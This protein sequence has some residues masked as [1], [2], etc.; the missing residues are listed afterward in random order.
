MKSKEKVNL[1]VVKDIDIQ[2]F[3]RQGSFKTKAHYSDKIFMKKGL[4]NTKNSQSLP[5]FLAK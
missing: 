1:E 2:N 3:G 5:L 4:K